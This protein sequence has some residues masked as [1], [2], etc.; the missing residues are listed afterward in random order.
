MTADNTPEDCPY[1]DGEL[2]E[3]EGRERV[4]QCSNV[5]GC[6]VTFVAAIQ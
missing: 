3:I 4:R 2:V 5:G 6:P 1:C